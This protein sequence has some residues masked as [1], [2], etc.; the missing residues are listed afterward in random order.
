LQ[1]DSYDANIKHRD[2][3]D[4]QPCFYQAQRILHAS[5]AYLRQFLVDDKGCVLIACWGMPNMSYLDNAHRALAAAAQIRPELERLHM[6]TSVGITCA[7][8]YCG[9]VGSLE[10]ME[11]AAIGSEVNMAAR[12]MGKAKGRLLVG[13]TAYRNLPKSDHGRLQ[14][15]PPLKVKGK[16]EPL[17]A[18]CYVPST[19][20]KITVKAPS[21]SVV[22]IP[23]SCKP[24]LLGLLESITAAPNSMSSSSHGS[25][26]HTLGAV[27]RMSFRAS[28]FRS[29]S[30][31]AAFPVRSAAHPAKV[32]VVKG[33]F[34]TGKSCVASWLRARAAERSIHVT[35]IRMAKM[36]G[37]RMPYTL[38]KKIFYQLTA[39]SDVRADGQWSHINDLLHHV[40]PN[41]AHLTDYVSMSALCTA[42]GVGVTTFESTTVP[43]Q[44]KPTRKNSMSFMIGT[45]VVKK[46]S[47]KQ[48][49]ENLRDA[50]VKI[51]AYL[52]NQ[53]PTL[54]IIENVHLIGERCLDLLV[55]LLPKL[56]HPS[57]IVLTAV[58]VDQFPAAGQ[59]VKATLDELSDSG[60]A[61]QV[62]A[63]ESSPWFMRYRQVLLSKKTVTVVELSTYSTLD[64]SAMLCKTLNLSTAP[65]EL[66]QLVQEFS[67]GS[68]FWVNEILQFIKEHGAENFLSAVS[69][70][71]VTPQPQ[72][73]A[74]GSTPTLQRRQSSSVA[75]APL[76]RSASTAKNQFGA[77][78]PS[79]AVSPYQAQLDKLVLVRFGGLSSETQRILR[80][81]SVIG[82]SLCMDVLHAVLPGHL[83]PALR[84]SL[85]TLVN[86]LWLLQ[87]TDNDQLY[88]FLH[89]HAQHIIY[90]L[91]PSSERNL[92]YAQIAEYVERK[93]GTD[94]AYFAMLS[95]YYLHCDTD[96]ALQYA[97]KAT[98]V[99]LEV[100]RIYDFADAITLLQNSVQACVSASDARVVQRLCENC[101]SAMEKF[102]SPLLAS[103]PD[104]ASAPL[105]FLQRF[106]SCWGRGGTRVQPYVLDRAQLEENEQAARDEFS[107]ALGEV[108]TSLEKFMSDSKEEV[109]DPK[110]WQVEF[111]AQQ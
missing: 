53:Q 109:P 20:E 68:Y 62:N 57:A 88:I 8:V 72:A 9:T 1:W 85:Q 22:D 12:L 92:L 16:S 45:A 41:M 99:L 14:E 84:P 3:L 33:K 73:Q 108:F 29:V 86:Q 52:F 34:G 25:S 90:E 66:L 4:L 102:R 63:L 106:T 104:N 95:H 47:V 69:A 67:G 93:Y 94:P 7:D 38:W 83:Q 59:S 60:N 36:V 24:V 78:V 31:A 82:P 49:Q 2:L 56:S 70:D 110:R 5:G 55:H 27:R 43:A 61:I 54:L 96:K 103:N 97:V 40:F 19:S 48:E 11:Y 100:H 30:I 91:T 76:R 64:I 77:P 15:I 51:F 32:V 107:R 23:P 71:S 28:S 39:K 37:R 17:Q 58:I 89:P 75:P 50:M 79:R 26:V 44:I 21:R 74:Q 35:N 111:L 10:R 6:E 105:H 13:D 98:A 46:P 80:T 87:D 18:Y 42:L 81:A 101:L 65:P